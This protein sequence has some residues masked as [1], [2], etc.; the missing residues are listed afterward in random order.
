MRNYIKT[1]YSPQSKNSFKY[2]MR[3]YIKTK[4]SQSKNSFKYTMHNYIKTIKYNRKEKQLKLK[5]FT[6]SDHLKSSLT[7]SENDLSAGLHH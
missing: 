2:T 1:K 3:N 7:V 6:Y 5:T 4:Y